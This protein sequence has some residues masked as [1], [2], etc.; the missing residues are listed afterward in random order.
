MKITIKGN[1]RYISYL[2]NHLKEEHPS[3]RKRMRKGQ[4]TVIALITVGFLLLGLILFIPL[5]K[6]TGGI[7][8]ANDGFLELIGTY[9]WLFILFAAIASYFVWVKAGVTQ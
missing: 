6:A 2:F 7:M 5:L 3:T 1:R 9:S 8:G 4:V